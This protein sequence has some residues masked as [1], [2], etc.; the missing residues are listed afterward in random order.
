M[1]E[2]TAEPVKLPDDKDITGAEFLQCFGKNRPIGFGDA[3]N[4]GMDFV[5][6]GFLQCVNLQIEVLVLCTDPS[7]AYF[8]GQPCR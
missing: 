6:T 8:H 4:F 7:I 3:D 1:A 5:H 2:R